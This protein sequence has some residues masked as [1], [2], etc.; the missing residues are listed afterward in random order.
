MLKLKL[1]YFGHLMRRVDSLGKTLMLGGVGGRKRRGR[2]RMRWLDGITDSMDVS[3]SELRELVMAREAWRAAIHGVTKS[4]TQLS[5]WTE[6]NWTELNNKKRSMALRKRKLPWDV[7]L[8]L[9]PASPWVLH[10]PMPSIG[11]WGQSAVFLSTVIW[12]P[13]IPLN[14]KILLLKWFIFWLHL[15]AC[16]IFIPWLGIEPGL[17]AVDVQGPNH[18]DTREVSKMIFKGIC[19]QRSLESCSP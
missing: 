5:D 17:P 19:G 6:L 10:S 4:R 14:Q 13:S 1:Q 8:G 3:L 12:L 16:K 2:Q 9:S 18:W 11:G 7:S 15:E